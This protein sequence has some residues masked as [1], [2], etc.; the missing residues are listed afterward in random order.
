M[1][2]RSKASV[3]DRGWGDRGFETPSVHFFEYIYIYISNPSLAYDSSLANDSRKEE[4][5]E[6]RR[7]EARREEEDWQAFESM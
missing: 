2:E 6:A 3:L 5:E 4:E 1:A 7:E